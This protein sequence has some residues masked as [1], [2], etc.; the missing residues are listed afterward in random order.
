MVLP[1]HE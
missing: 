1:K